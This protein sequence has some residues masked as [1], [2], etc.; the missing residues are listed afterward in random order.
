MNAKSKQKQPKV[1]WHCP[2]AKL[3]LLQRQIPMPASS[4]TGNILFAGCAPSF[5]STRLC[6]RKTGCLSSSVPMARPHPWSRL[7]LSNAAALSQPETK[8]GS[9]CR[10]CKRDRLCPRR[11]QKERGPPE[12]LPQPTRPTQNTHNFRKQMPCG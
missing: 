6:L 9:A 12:R 4:G 7:S 5:D 2:V 1:D 10:R 8:A 11:R 3:Y